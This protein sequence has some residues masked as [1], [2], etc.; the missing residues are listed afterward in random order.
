MTPI[1][2]TLDG[3]TV[4]AEPGTTL[5]EAARAQGV[6]LPHLC[7]APGLRP[8]GNCRACMVEVDGERVLAASCCRAVSAGTPRLFM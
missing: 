4:H 6:H 2:F 7:H 5:W 3:V 1:E 8:D